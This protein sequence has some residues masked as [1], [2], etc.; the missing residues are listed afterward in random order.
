MRRPLSRITG[1]R[2]GLSTENLLFSAPDAPGTAR[3]PGMRRELSA[4]VLPG[5]GHAA[6]PL[7]GRGYFIGNMSLRLILNASEGLDGLPSL[8]V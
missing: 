3:L 8:S 2:G 4:V 7:A 6:F 5:R 1:R